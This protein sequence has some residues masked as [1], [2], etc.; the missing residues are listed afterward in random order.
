MPTRARFIPVLTALFLI[1]CS[2][3]EKSFKTAF[4]EE[5]VAD[6]YNTAMASMEAGEYE[7]AAKSFYDVERQHPYSKW[8]ARAQVMA[9]YA[10]Y[11]GENYDAAIE[12]ADRFLKLHPGHEEAPYAL[13]LKALSYYDRISDVQRD[14]KMTR[15]AQK[16]LKE[17]VKRYPDTDYARD[18]KMKLDLTRDHLAGKHMAIGR[19]YLNQQQFLAA[20]NRF[21]TVV[22]DYQTTTHTPEALYRLVEAYASL[23]LLKEAR[24]TAAVLGYNYPESEWFELSYWILEGGQIRPGDGS[25]SWLGLPF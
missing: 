25:R 17:V 9:A 4:E 14:Q 3:Q 10:N 7:E 13:Y 22:E 18:A 12:A 2:G 23:G 16:H 5:P 21:K 20:V 1:A 8:A 24:R 19:Y 15:R 11:K 6:L